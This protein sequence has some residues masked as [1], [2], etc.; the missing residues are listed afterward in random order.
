MRLE[1]DFLFHFWPFPNY[2]CL[3]YSLLFPV[4]SF[5]PV[6]AGSF[7]L[8]NRKGNERCQS[9]IIMIMWP[10]LHDSKTMP[11][12]FPTHLYPPFLLQWFRGER[13]WSLW[14]CIL[15]HQCH[16]ANERKKSQRNPATELIRKWR[17]PV[18]QLNH[19]FIIWLVLLSPWKCHFP[20][21][22]FFTFTNFTVRYPLSATSVQSL[23]K[24]VLETFCE[25]LFI[26][27]WSSHRKK[28]TAAWTKAIVFFTWQ[29]SQP[30]ISVWC[31]C[32]KAL[33]RTSYN[34]GKT[35]RNA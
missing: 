6:S 3:T 13:V 23:Q 12:A 1:L 18:A 17:G 7:V 14:G 27:L 28:N 34:S 25:P 31:A 26:A 21:Q 8:E 5:V 33:V 15:E 16:K 32:V 10:G 9:M 30:A 11:Q 24:L 20:Y 19:L 35:S 4:F 22:S 29:E 2:S